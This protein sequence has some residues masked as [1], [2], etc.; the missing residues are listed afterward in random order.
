MSADF[1][2]NQIIRDTVTE[3]FIQSFNENLM[4]AL[5]DLY[6]DASLS[7][8]LYEDHIADGYRVD[9][10]FYY[11]LTVILP[12]GP[13]I[14][15]ISWQVSNYRLYDKFNPFSYKGSELLTFNAEA[16]PPEQLVQKQE[17][18]AICFDGVGMPLSVTAPVEDKT[19]LSG[20]YSQRFAD[21]LSMQITRRIEEEL[22]IVG[23]AESGVV[24][25]LPFAPGSFLEHI[26]GNTTYRRIL[27]KARGCAARDLWIKW[28]RLDRKGNYTVA[29]SV[30]EADILFE[31][32]EEVSGK[33]K[34]KEY[35]YLTSGSLLEYQN[36]MSRKNI[37]GWREMMR[38][39]IK[40]GEVLKTDTPAKKE[41]VTEA[42]PTP[43]VQKT[44]EIPPVAEPARAE[45]V[46]DRLSRILADIED[47]REEEEEDINS[48]LTDLLKSAMG[49]KD[50]VR[51]PVTVT[52]S[53]KAEPYEVPA[54]NEPAVI[55]EP[56]VTDET[57]VVEEP[58]FVEEPAVA[59]ADADYE[60]RI[61]RE[62]EAKLR[63]EMEEELRRGREEAE[64]LRARLEAQLR[65]EARE[66]ELMAEAAM[67]SLE[68]QRRL[69]KEREAERERIRKD[70]ERLAE[71]RRKAEEEQRA[72]EEAR[73][74]AE[75]EEKAKAE[76]AKA[77]AASGEPKYVSKTARL[78]FKYSVAQTATKKIHEI[79]LATIKYF[80]KEDV[81]IR[82]KATV[83]DANTVVLD[84]VK[85]PENEIPLLVNIIKVL[86]KS[87]LGIIK[88]IL[89]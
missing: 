83:P 85:I 7:V 6:G 66:K 57:A 25:E 33:I 20:K 68:E 54:F 4:P 8:Q 74:K 43:V 62:L 14:R 46:S 37:T 30:T 78:I 58:T 44:E 67:A 61:R 47:E 79:I 29:D 17:G 88:A 52:P 38:R 13:H 71:A 42:I 64:E 21:E 51:E 2:H 35:R 12:E 10:V 69:E 89:D 24:L 39:V 80:H 63:A 1:F 5:C 87:D 59:A 41:P 50:G 65:A 22:S 19:F 70:E 9:G 56:T 34:E 3:R 81:Y 82:I 32:A 11:P 48:D 36:A 45:S 18:R 76:A 28:T 31:L 53:V 40:R 75:A 27:I 73:R 16:E 23:L 15:W 26:V 77:E 86:G 84:F 49:I 60:A 72:L 55:D